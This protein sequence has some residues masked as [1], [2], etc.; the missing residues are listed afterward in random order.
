MKETKQKTLL[1]QTSI[2][3]NS[4]QSLTHT[5]YHDNNEIIVEDKNKIVV[6]T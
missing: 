1:A 3:E 2:S 6:A 4:S 5:T